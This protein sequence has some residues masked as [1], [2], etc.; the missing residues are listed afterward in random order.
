MQTSVSEQQATIVARGDHALPETHALLQ[1]LPL[2]VCIVD[3]A[4]C[5]VSMNA[6]AERLLG[7]TAHTWRG[8]SLH[9]LLGCWLTVPGTAESCCPLAQVLQTG[10]PVWAAQ[11]TVHGHNDTPL[12]VELTCM[13]LA[14]ASPA[15]AV[16]SFRDLRR[17]QQ[18][19]QEL[20][21]LA[22]V[23]EDNPLPIVELDA[24]AHLLYAN[25]AMMALLETGG[26]TQA[27][28]PKVLPPTIMALV[29]T[30]LRT[31]VGQTALPGGTVQPYIEWTLCPLPG[32]NVVRAYGVDLTARHQAEQ[33]LREAR[34][35]VLTA[36]RLK[37]EF[38]ANVS[39]ELRTPLNGI[40]GMTELL[41]VDGQNLSNLINKL[42]TD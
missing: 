33:M 39:H 11:T 21:R 32:G 22:S 31:G 28:L 4:G 2:G 38:M 8:Y 19:H 16:I 10:R 12:P 36:W 24:A 37:S 6:E 34:D 13:P 29:H 17:Q 9:P 1:A 26:F 41:L 14:E 42:R 27:G 3:A 7:W 20:L 35:A 18:M 30:C 5:L 40:L 25:P 23:L 15:G